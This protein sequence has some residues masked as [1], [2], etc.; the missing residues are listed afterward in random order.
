MLCPWGLLLA[1]PFPQPKDKLWV[2][3]ELLELAAPNEACPEALKVW[4]QTPEPLACVTTS[5]KS[6]DVQLS[7]LG[8][9]RQKPAVAGQ[10]MLKKARF[11]FLFSI[12][13]PE[14]SSCPSASPPGR[15]R[16]FLWSEAVAGA[17]VGR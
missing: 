7:V 11:F 10:Q 9:A 12:F 8:L 15:R 1:I 3:P 6:L 16:Q 17:E 5:A 13:S 14:Q 2:C 4:D